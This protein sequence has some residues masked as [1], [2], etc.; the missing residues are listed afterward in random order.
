MASCMCCRTITFATPINKSNSAT[1]T[2]S[3]VSSS[4]NVEIV[5]K[6]KKSRVCG[7]RASMVD[8][9]ESSSN[10]VHRMEQAWLISQVSIQ[11]IF[12]VLCL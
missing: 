4:R 3:F 5:V 12:R 9:Y 6:S 11:F 10:F 1:S 7:A 8:S 2:S